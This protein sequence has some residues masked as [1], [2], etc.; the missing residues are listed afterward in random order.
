MSLSGWEI[1]FGAS[2][3]R[4]Q[5]QSISPLDGSWTFCLGHDLPGRFVKLAAGDYI[6][7]KQSGDISAAALIRVIAHLRAAAT[8]PAG[9]YWRFGLYIDGVEV[10]GRD[11][12]QGF[13]ERTRVDMAAN[14]SNLAAVDHEIALRLSVLGVAGSYDVELPAAYIDNVVLEP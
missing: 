4:I 8:I 13:V 14:A 10:K 9:L 6:E 5:P 11:L 2:Q 7:V 1:N 12:P 3:G